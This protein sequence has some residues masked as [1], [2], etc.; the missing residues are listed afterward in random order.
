[1]ALVF[2][3][4][5]ETGDLSEFSSTTGSPSVVSTHPKTGTY[6]MQCDTTGGAATAFVTSTPSSRRV[7]FYLYIATTPNVE[8]TIIG[9]V[10]SSHVELDTDRHLNLYDTFGVLEGEGTTVLNTSTWYRISFSND[11]AGNAKVFINGSEEL[12]TATMSSQNITGNLGIVESSTADLFFDDFIR[13]GTSSTA[14]LGDIRVQVALPIGNG[15]ENVYDQA[16]GFGLCNNLP[17]DSD[18]VEDNGADAAREQFEVTTMTNL[19]ISGD[20][21]QAINVIVRID[22]DGGGGTTHS[23]SVRDNATDFETAT[24]GT[25]AWTQYDKYY[26][27]LPSGGGAWTEVRFDALEAGVYHLGPQDQRCSTV[28]VMLAYTPA[29]VGNGDIVVLRRRREAE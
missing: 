5:F 2:H 15:N 17:D 21:L 9:A 16:S 23:I 27:T 20:T 8:I 4:G 24:A 28:N 12:T 18:Y 10:G 19:G 14:D 6:E 11:G 25:G 22:R 3:S 13:D 26:A 7:S 1:M 29:V